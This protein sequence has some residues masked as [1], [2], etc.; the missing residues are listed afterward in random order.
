M[1]QRFVLNCRECKCRVSEWAVVAMLISNPKVKLF[2]SSKCMNVFISSRVYVTRACKC[3]IKEMFC[4]NCLSCVGYHVTQPCLFCLRNNSNGHLFMFN[5][6]TVRY[7][8]HRHTRSR[9]LETE[10]DVEVRLR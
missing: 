9:L 6:E 10:N 8:E 7:T 4:I 2:S 3:F 5:F 1:K